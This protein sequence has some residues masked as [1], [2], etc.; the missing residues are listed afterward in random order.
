[1]RYFSPY[2]GKRPEK[3]EFQTHSPIPHPPLPPK[4]TEIRKNDKKGES[5]TCPKIV[6]QPAVTSEKGV[7]FNPV[8]SSSGVLPT[9]IK[10]TCSTRA[11]GETSPFSDVR[12]DTFPSAFRT[13]PKI[14]FA[15]LRI[16]F[17]LGG[18]M[19]DWIFSGLFPSYDEKY[20]HHRTRTRPS[21]LNLHEEINT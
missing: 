1:M 21:F 16:S 5:R 2:D 4:K 18:K 14:V 12:A 8:R 13:F 17:L 19:R 3:I 11:S 9:F 15:F 6:A 20:L 7:V 10:L